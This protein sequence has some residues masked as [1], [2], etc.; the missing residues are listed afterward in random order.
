MVYWNMTSLAFTM[1]DRII[2]NAKTK[3][4]VLHGDNIHEF[5]EVTQ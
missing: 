4:V 3:P 1:T 5:S 2:L